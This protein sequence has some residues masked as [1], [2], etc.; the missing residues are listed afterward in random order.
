MGSAGLRGPG[1]RA[2]G[3]RPFVPLAAPLRSRGAGRRGRRSSRRRGASAGRGGVRQPRL[4]DRRD[5]PLRRV[6]LA[7][8]YR[9]Q[10]RGQGRSA[11]PLHGWRRG[12]LARA[13]A[14]PRARRV[15]PRHRLRQLALRD[16][17]RLR[18][19]ARGRG[20]SR[21]RRRGQPLR[22]SLL[23]RRLLCARCHE[24][25]RSKPTLPRRGRRLDPSRGRRLHRARA[26]RRCSSRGPPRARDP[27][28]RRTLQRRSRARLLGP[29][30]G[31]PAPSDR[32]GLP[33]RRD[34]S[35]PRLAARVP[36]DRHR[37]RRHD[38]A[39]QQRGRVRRARSRRARDRLAQVQPRPLDH[40]RGRRRVDQGARGHAP[41]PAPGQPPRRRAQ[42]R[43]RR[44]ALSRGSCARALDRRA[45]DRRDLGLRLR[46]QQ[47][48]L[49]RQRGRS[50]L[51]RGDPHDPRTRRPARGRRDRC[52]GCERPRRACLR[53]RV[54][55][56]RELG[57]ARSGRHRRV[58]TRARGSAFSAQRSAPHLAPTAA[59][60]RRGPRGDARS[61]ARVRARRR[62]PRDRDRP[63]GLSLR[64]ALAGA[65]SAART[66]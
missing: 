20:R 6:G 41:R 33:A 9:D 43:A 22:R 19:A 50:D 2:R 7:G 21:A 12:G 40:R 26:A 66:R 29:E 11:Q 1:R 38:R 49:D 54:A 56:R 31:R 35:A 30:R 55:D 39:P 5:E 25:H 15:L 60:A 45:Q 64:R 57:R 46:R 16:Q 23:A 44:H 37:R 62:V 52:P 8:R 51:A 47:C 42:P 3:T 18:S 48:P 17:A 34:R 61:D 32:R 65:D 14:R 53:A 28:R 10:E 63:R 4:P 27:A 36:R 59:G 13:R 24:P 58:R